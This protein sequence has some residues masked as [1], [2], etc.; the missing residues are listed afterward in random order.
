MGA[1]TRSK[2]LQ[3][4]AMLVGLFLVAGAAVAQDQTQTRFEGILDAF[5]AQAQGW[6]GVLTAAAE[7]LFFTL[8]TIS[9]LWAN[10]NMALRGGDASDFIRINTL[11]V[12]R[13]GVMWVFLRHAYEWSSAMVVGFRQA[14]ERAVIASGGAGAEPT[15]DPAGVFQ[16]GMIVAGSLFSQMSIW[17]GP[18]NLSL[19]ICALVMIFCFA[20]L[21]A[22]MAVAIV[23]SYIVIGGSVLFLGFGGSPWTIEIAKRTL[24]YCVSIGAKLFALQLIVGV[25]MGSVLTWA[26][27]Y[28]SDSSTN[29]LGLIGLIL[30]ITVMAK[31]I[32]ELVQGML[33]GASVGGA[34][35]M[36]ATGAAAV[37]AAVTG[38]AAVMT[39]G[40]AAGAAGAGAAGSSA[41]GAATTGAQGA[42][43]YA[44]AA[45]NMAGA[46][47]RAAS[48]G[49]DM[50]GA[51]ATAPLGP[52]G[53]VARGVVGAADSVGSASAAASKA[54]TGAAGASSA[55]GPASASGVGG[56]G[57]VA[58][59]GQRATTAGGASA[60]AGPGGEGNGT[61]RGS[62]L[63]GGTDDGGAGAGGAAQSGASG[64]SAGS[65]GGG[66][67]GGGGGSGASPS[68]ADPVG[69][70]TD[71]DSGP[72]A[73]EGAT[74]AAFGTG[75]GSARG[76]ND[77]GGTQG[78]R[79]AG[80]GS[81]SRG[82]AVPEGRAAMLSDA[83]SKGAEAFG[84]IVD[85]ATGYNP[86][87]AI[88]PQLAG[89]GGAPAPLSDEDQDDAGQSPDGG[90]IRGDD[91]GD[92]ARASYAKRGAAAGFVAAGPGGAAIGAA[93]GAAAGPQL[94]E[95]AKRAKSTLEK[96]KR[97]LTDDPNQK[98]TAP[99][100]DPK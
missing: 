56:V 75:G 6:Q 54:S 24:M 82:E 61:S 9:F 51:A 4:G 68:I 44:G 74:G 38:T 28:E 34:G 93:L 1:G 18:D 55:S 64:A 53:A 10:M 40:A 12:L 5:A 59:G 79:A 96:A 92:K 30:L 16:N 99:K 91:S 57:S 67:G 72:D 71:G 23:E 84:H 90:T 81:V 22:F 41:A 11:E 62:R 21:A 60:G 98:P 17:S 39:G 26:Q 3:A 49:S 63:A 89:L 33:N 43:A 42:A 20:F 94:D 66:G 88:A 69:L 100:S 14:G 86:G 73:S 27:S 76:G 13:I 46:A 80:Q 83:S 70:A 19:V 78:D 25:A 35:A 2:W 65:P 87:G 50:A 97:A 95:A 32:P 8:A 47:G 29:T 36:L 45:G 31:M 48:A 37:A 77:G 58:S 7:W 85:T 15:L 52:L